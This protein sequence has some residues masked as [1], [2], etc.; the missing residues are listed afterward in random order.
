MTPLL[1]VVRNVASLRWRTPGVELG[2]ASLIVAGAMLTW[3]GLSSLLACIGALL[4]NRAMFAA[5]E[6]TLR[7]LQ[8]A[9]TLVWIAHN[10]AVGSPLAVLREALVFTSNL[11]GSWRLYRRGDAGQS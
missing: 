8:L 7:A 4:A 11:L 2:F 1:A 3:G 6:R 9:A 5:S 10:L